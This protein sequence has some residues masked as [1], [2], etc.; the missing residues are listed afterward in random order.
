MQKVD[1]QTKPGSVAI[2]LVALGN[3]CRAALT[4]EQRKLEMRAQASEPAKLM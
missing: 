2:P 3:S 1:A 4:T